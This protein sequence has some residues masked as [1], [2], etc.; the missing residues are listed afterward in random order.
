MQRLGSMKG[1]AGLA[2]LKSKHGESIKQD[3]FFRLRRCFA[4]NTQRQRGLV[5]ARPAVQYDRK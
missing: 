3:T 4:E 5:F 1:S 2:E